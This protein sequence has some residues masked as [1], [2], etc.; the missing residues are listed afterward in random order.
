MLARCATSK[1][2]LTR[3]EPPIRAHDVIDETVYFGP[4]PGD[5]H[6]KHFA[7]LTDTAT[8]LCAAALAYRA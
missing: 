8:Q 3:S 5:E 6:D 1:G 2:D 4:A 7:A